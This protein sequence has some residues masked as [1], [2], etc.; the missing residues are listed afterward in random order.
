M[1][2]CLIIGYNDVAFDTYVSMLR[3]MGTDKGA[4]RDLN[5]A[6]VTHDGTP[7]R[8]MD[9]LN[10]FNE[11]V[12]ASGRRFS[13]VDFLWPVITYLYT[14]LMRRGFT[15]SYVNLFQ[16]ERQALI[17]QLA[18]GHVR[19][20]AITTTLYVWM[21][22]ILE[23]VDLVRQYSPQTTIIVGGP[24]IQNQARALDAS[25]LQNLLDSIGADVYVISTEGEATLARTLDHLRRGVSLAAVPNLVYRDGE[26]MV[27]TESR[28]EENSL[29]DEMVDYSLFP[30]DRFRGFVNLRTAKSC[31]FA[32]AFCAYPERAGAYTYL[33]VPLIEQELDGIRRLESV[34]TLSFI[35]DTFNVP[36][37][38]FKDILRMMIRNNYGFRWN[39]YLRADHVDAECL[40][41]MEQSGC[42]GVFLG[43]ES[44]SD[45]I[46]K[47]MN[48]TARRI[49]YE[50]IIPRLR[51]A[52]I[53]THANLIVGFPG[54]TEDTI[55][56]SISLIETA[57]P[58]FYRAQ[59]WYC[60]PTTPVWRQREALGITGSAF[61]WS[62]PT[63][64]SDAACNWVERLF[65]EITGA[66]WLPQFGFETWSL[67]YLQRRGMSLDQVKAFVRAFNAGVNAKLLDPH[68]E[69]VPAE[70]LATMRAAGTLAPAAVMAT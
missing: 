41:L 40:E 9:L 42:E 7:Y 61:T 22:P 5:L 36:M 63:L 50:T 19:S 24:Y 10:L 59:L 14:Y 33:S 56:E 45:R 53:I 69:Q 39:S 47:A 30:A 16:D 44:G 15:A 66:I 31:P 51:D 29:A 11:P 49:N 12:I 54:E 34:T 55:A 25:T 2:D 20:V 23:I 6:F 43:V 26:Q 18:S 58:D 4:Y 52:G 21:T 57:R 65:R 62:H 13:N 27:Q 32:C 70:L 64:D 60:D 48:K 38:R 17:D 46:L 35:D 1:I 67:Y 8:S 68:R 28:P 3:Q 37:K